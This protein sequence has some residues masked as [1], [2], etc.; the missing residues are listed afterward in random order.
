MIENRRPPAQA[1]VLGFYLAHLLVPLGL[2]IDASWALT[3]TTRTW[4]AGAI[5]V[6]SVTWLVL[7]IAVLAP[8]RNRAR[9]LAR[10]ARPLLS[11]YAGIFCLVVFEGVAFL[12][13][14]APSLY[15]PGWQET[16]QRP[17]NQVLP[18]ASSTVRISMNGD[19]LRGLPY[20]SEAGSYRI[21]AIGG[22]T[23][24]CSELDDSK[25]WETRLAEEIS[26]RRSRTGV[27]VGNAGMNGSTTVECQVVLQTLLPSKPLDTV[28]F[29]VGFNDLEVALSARGEA[30][31]QRLQ[32]NADILRSQIL[33][34]GSRDYYLSRYPLVRRLRLYQLVRNAASRLGF[35]PSRL[36]MNPAG[37]AQYRENR[38][39]AP[40]V[41]LPDLSTGLN[42]YG[43]R[44]ERLGA[45][46]RQQKR[47]CLFLT[48]P[49][50]WRAGMPPAEE[51]LLWL[52]AVGPGNIPTATS[53]RRM[54]PAPWTRI[55]TYCARSARARTWN[56][57]IWPP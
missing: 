13:P 7:G 54:A 3:V 23:T 52:G 33:H 30:T 37:Y 24:L 5:L 27:W 34:G 10:C 41:P 36:T 50:L 32:A 38:A 20:P 39:K 31:E 53:C 56:A 4:S 35:G 14:R 44:I 46:C 6:L 17:A 26:Q 8:A 19:G 15:S 51:S 47:R 28:L 57:W 18:G 16:F 2:A 49:V 25:T 11:F 22:S 55:T 29:L 1:V 45:L 9:F 40:I 48:Q 12:I 21:L 43:Q 42:E